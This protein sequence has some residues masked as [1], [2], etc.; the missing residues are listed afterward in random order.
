MLSVDAGAMGEE[1]CRRALEAGALK[2]RVIE[3]ATVV[4]APW[5]RW[6]CQYGCA[7]YGKSLCCP[8]HSPRPEET[9]AVLRCY[10]YAVLLLAEHSWLVR[11][12]AGHLERLAVKA[13]FYKAFGLGAGPCGLCASCAPAGACRRPAEA[14]PAM[15]A[16]GIDVFQTVRNNDLELALAANA[17]QPCARAGLVLL[18]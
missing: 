2:A 18:E 12:L 16:C 5:V 15:E 7:Q 10:R 6:K 3:A 14:R 4:T 8:P 11:Y 13:G 9:A 17:D 1:L